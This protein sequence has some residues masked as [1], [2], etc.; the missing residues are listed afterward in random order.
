MKIHHRD[1]GFAE[2][3]V[4]PAKAGIQFHP[5]ATSAPQRCNLRIFSHCRDMRD[6]CSG[7][8]PYSP[9]YLVAIALA[10]LA[11]SYLLII[12]PTVAR[13]G[14]D[15]EYIETVPAERVKKLLDS[16]EK[17]LLVDLRPAGDFQKARLPGAISIPVSELQKRHHEI[18]KSGRVILYCA[19]P[20]GGVDESYS[21]L[22]L[23]GKGYRNVSVLEDGFS[24]WAQ[25]KF[26]VMSR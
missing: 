4:I 13:A 5:S 17:I 24:G 25:R 18:P 8:W 10:W 1:T 14:H 15:D 2:G 26:P 6:D 11:V 20:P 22:A 19:C 16:G 9:T 3:F 23:R 21:Y 7:P 12:E